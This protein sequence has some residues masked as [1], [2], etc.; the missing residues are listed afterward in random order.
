[1]IPFFCKY[2]LCPFFVAAG[3]HHGHGCRIRTVLGEHD[4]VGPVNGSGYPFCQVYVDIGR[5]GAAGTEACLFRIIVILSLAYPR[6]MGPYA[7][8]NQD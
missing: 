7:T 1:M 4:L 2:D 8:C 6:I 3:Q 5:D